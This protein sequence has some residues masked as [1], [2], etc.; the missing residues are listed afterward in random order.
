MLP[1]AILGIGLLIGAVLL[2]KW[3]ANADPAVIKRVLKWT[4]IYALIALAVFLALTGRLAAAFGVLAGTVA[5]GWRL[6]NMVQMFRQVSGLFGGVGGFGGFGGA[7]QGQTSDVSAR[8][9]RMTL[10]HD[11]GVMDGRVLEGRYAGRN[12][13]GMG[14]DDLLDFLR[15]IAADT[16]SASLLEA[17]LD[18]THADWRSRFSGEGGAH[19]EEG[20]GSRSGSAMTR[21]EAYRILGLEPGVSNEEIKAAYRRLMAKIH[22]DHGGSPYFAAQLNQARDLLLKD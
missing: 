6:L 15:E 13:N 18:R 7:R 9:L 1:S 19:G 21:E 16:D 20:G 10:D 3:Y 17:Y 8:Y 2:M 4:G 5:W 14:L 11:T 12:L 22:P